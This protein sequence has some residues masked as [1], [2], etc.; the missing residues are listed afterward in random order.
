MNS[1]ELH[2]PTGVYHCEMMDKQNVTHYLYVGI[3]LENEGIYY[4]HIR[5]NKCTSYNNIIHLLLYL[6]VYV[7]DRICHYLIN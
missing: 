2:V 3:Y 5:V 6:F 1:P 4:T 7:Y